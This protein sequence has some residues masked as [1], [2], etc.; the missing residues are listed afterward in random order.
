MDQKTIHVVY[1][2][3]LTTDMTNNFFQSAKMSIMKSVVGQSCIKVTVTFQ[4][5][6]HCTFPSPIDFYKRT[7]V[8]FR[9]CRFSSSIHD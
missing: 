5:D 7:R 6:E 4:R 8:I 3:P 2:C 1:G 9:K